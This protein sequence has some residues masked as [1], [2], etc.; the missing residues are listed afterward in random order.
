[1]QKSKWPQHVKFII[2]TGHPEDNRIDAMRPHHRIGK[3]TSAAASVALVIEKCAAL[4]G[5]ISIFL[6]SSS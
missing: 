1:M 6:P 5:N 2:H 3:G 4:D